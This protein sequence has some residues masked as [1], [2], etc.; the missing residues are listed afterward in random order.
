M[1]R[2]ADQLPWRAKPAHHQEQRVEKNVVMTRNGRIEQR[3]D[4]C[5][6]LASEIADASRQARSDHAERVT[7][8]QDRRKFTHIIKR[9][10]CADLTDE[11]LRSFLILGD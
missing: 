9:M 10:W 6:L 8:T 1:N 7:Q 5:Q 2:E 4:V 3:L 11:P